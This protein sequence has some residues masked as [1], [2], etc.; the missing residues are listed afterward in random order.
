MSVERPAASAAWA[1]VFFHKAPSVLAEAVVLRKRCASIV[2]K[3]FGWI[4]VVVV[5]AENNV[6]D[7]EVDERE[8]DFFSFVLKMFSEGLAAVCDFLNFF[9]SLVLDES[10]VFTLTPASLFLPKPL[11]PSGRGS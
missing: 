3:G 4:G 7:V 11:W 8:V 10:D 5:V 6:S 9:I 1:T 2:V